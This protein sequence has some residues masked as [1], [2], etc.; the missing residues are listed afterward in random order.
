MDIRQTTGF[1]DLCINVSPNE[2]HNWY[3]LLLKLH[4]LGFKTVAINTNLDES[5]LGADRKKKKRHDGE[6]SQSIIPEVVDIE[7]IKRDFHGKLKVFNRISFLCSDPAKTHALNHCATL[8]KYDLYAFVPKT[9]NALQFACTQLN[10]DIITLKSSSTTFK[11]NK[12]LYEQA[13]ER[14]IHFE[15]QYTDL[16]NIESRKLTIHYS[17]LFHTY[18]KSKNVILSSGSNDVN[19]VR[20]PY[21]LINLSCLLG[22]NEIKAKASILS[23]CKKLLLRA[24]R[25]RRGKAA[26]IIEEETKTIDIIEDDGRFTKRL[27]S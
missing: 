20:N 26:F 2:K 17:H 10:T 27:K 23:Q 12:K 4:E 22:L 16:L 8:K 7:N 24:E 13:V 18:G 21:D 6:P 3:P 9:Q 1:Y 25:R 15:I 11:L 14:G 19:S 5:I